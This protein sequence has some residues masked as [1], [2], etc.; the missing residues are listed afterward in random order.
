MEFDPN[1]YYLALQLPFFPL[2][3]TLN[4][5]IWTSEVELSKTHLMIGQWLNDWNNLFTI[6]SCG[7]KVKYCHKLQ[8][9]QENNLPQVGPNVPSA[10]QA[11]RMLSS[12]AGRCLTAGGRRMSRVSRSHSKGPGNHHCLHCQGKLE[13]EKQHKEADNIGF[14]IVKPVLCGCPLKKTWVN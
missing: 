10:V 12:A 4:N 11:Q 8:R 1:I 7:H 13:W 6:L 5:C 3:W 2:L 9:G 14:K